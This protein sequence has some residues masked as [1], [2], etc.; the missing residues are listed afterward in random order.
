MSNKEKLEGVGGW[1][2]FFIITIMIVS[3]IYS[4]IILFSEPLMT[5]FDYIEGLAVI[6]TLVLSGIFLINKKYYAITF[7]KV[8]LISMFLTALLY[9]FLEDYTIIQSVFYSIIWF[10]YLSYSDRVKNTYDKIKEPK[11]GGFIW[12][13]FAIIFA[14]LAPLSGLLFSIVS[15]RKISKHRKLKGMGLSI[16]ALIISIMI[17]V[18]FIFISSL[19]SYAPEEVELE[20][21]NYCY[22]L[23]YA[24]MYMV[25]PTVDLDIYNCVCTDENENEVSSKEIHT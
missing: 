11:E 4:F 16:T 19:S 10:L 12:P 17:F 5:T 25:L 24:S 8:V 13:K 9:I 3:P 2:L 21:Y 22:D 18:F 23:E 1:L 7:T 14:F 6:S 15:L 20:C